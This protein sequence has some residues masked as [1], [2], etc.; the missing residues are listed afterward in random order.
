MKNVLHLIIVEFLMKI[1]IT[2]IIQ[3]KKMYTSV[4]LQ[5]DDRQKYKIQYNTAR[6]Y[7]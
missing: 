1:I 5:T 6:T 4:Q 3:F 7:R 2:N